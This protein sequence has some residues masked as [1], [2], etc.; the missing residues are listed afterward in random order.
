M[1]QFR[2][3][4]DGFMRVSIEILSFRALAR[5]AKAS[6]RLRL[7]RLSSPCYALVQGDSLPA[8]SLN[9]YMSSSSQ[10]TDIQRFHASNPECGEA[11]VPC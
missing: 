6:R 8:I 5:A 7:S 3:G 1:A 4:P 11:R 2:L 10:E 9:H